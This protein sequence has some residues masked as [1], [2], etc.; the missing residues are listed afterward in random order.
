MVIFR[1]SETMKPAHIAAI[2]AVVGIGAYLLHSRSS[3]GALDY[4]SWEQA[5]EKARS[6]KKPILLNFGG[7]W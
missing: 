4:V 6:E 1:R 3:A 2:V 7:P 5:I